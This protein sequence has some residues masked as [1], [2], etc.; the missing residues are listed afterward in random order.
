MAT[1]LDFERQIHQTRP[2]A[3]LVDDLF[4]T[5]ADRAL[6]RLEAV[7]DGR[8]IPEAISEAQRAF[9]KL[10]R[11]HQGKAHALPQAQICAML[12]LDARQVRNVVQDLRVKYGVEVGA[13]RDADGGGYYLISTDAE[14]EESTAVMY[15]QAVSM[16]RT[17][18]VMR[19]GKQ[20]V[21]ELLKTIRRALT[22]E[23]V[24]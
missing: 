24:Q 23:A 11:R 12:K 6:R 15:Q 5:H 3:P 17:V 14:G 18:L 13:S 7:L 2:A 22:E 19:G 4:T 16:L 10:L 1:D 8:E 20:S 9:L 21:D